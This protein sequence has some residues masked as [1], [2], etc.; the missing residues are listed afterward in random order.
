V[1]AQFLWEIIVAAILLIA[2]ILFAESRR[3]KRKADIGAE[4]ETRL[5]EEI[6]GPD[7]NLFRHNNRV[8]ADMLPY[9]LPSCVQ[10]VYAD[11]NQA[12]LAGMPRRVVP[13]PQH[14]PAARQTASYV[15]D[16]VPQ[17]DSY[18]E[19]AR[20]LRLEA[21]QVTASWLPPERGEPRVNPLYRGTGQFPT[22]GRAA[23]FG[24]LLEDVNPVVRDLHAAIGKLAGS[25][26]ELRALGGQPPRG[27]DVFVAFSVAGGTG[28]GIFY[29]YLHLIGDMF[30]ADVH[31]RVQIY[32]LVLMPSGNPPVTPRKGP[33]H[34]RAVA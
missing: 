1:L 19:L 34:P 18:P 20:N 32:P 10:F 5:R 8:G 21:R 15:E 30:R 2:A 26:A 9:Q 11:M 24:T 12:A 17:V 7:G 25:A 23:L 13:G 31:L 4:L 28:S 3:R 14:I 27:V 16:L 6:C 29:D 33:G 22:I